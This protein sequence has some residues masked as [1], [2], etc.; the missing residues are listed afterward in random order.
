[1]KE[2]YPQALALTSDNAVLQ[3]N[4]L[5]LSLEILNDNITHKLYDKRDAIG[6]TIVN[7]PDLS[8]NIPKKHSYGVFVSQLI[9]YARCCQ[10]R[11]D[12]ID[13]SKILMDRVVN[14]NFSLL[15]LKRSF[16]KFAVSHYELLFK[17]RMSTNQ[18]YCSFCR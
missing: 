13:R 3:T 9:R 1:M 5:D 12:F 8:G 16:E 2:I 15:Q 17:Y 6:F 10:E 7:F 14:Q 4:Y 11:V 18:L